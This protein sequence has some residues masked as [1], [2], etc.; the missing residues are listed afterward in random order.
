MARPLRVLFVA[1]EIAPL[2]SSGELG[3]AVGGLAGALK[4]LGVDVRVVIPKYKT[5]QTQTSGATRLVPKM[6]IQTI[7]RFGETAI[8]R[9]EL[10]GELPV[11]LLEKDKYFQREYLYGSPEQGYED[12]AERFS[13]F[14]LATLES[15]SQIGFYPDV[16]H[17]HDWHTGLIPVY[18][19]TLFKHDP[20]YTPFKTAYTIHDLLHQGRFTWNDF[21][22]TGL[23]EAI[24][25]QEGLEYYG[26]FS[27][28]KAGIVYADIVNTVSKRYSQEIQT[29]DYGYGFEGL[30]QLR[31]HDLYG[32]LNGV[33]YKQ[34]NPRM[35]AFIAANYTRDE[36][37]KKRLCKADLLSACQWEAETHKP[38]IGMIAPLDEQK[39]VDLL[40][41]VLPDIVAQDVQMI[42]LHNDSFYDHFYAEQLTKMAV[43]YPAQFRYYPDY[44]QALAHKILAGADLLLL[45]SQK[46][47]CGRLQMYSLKYGTIPLVRATGGLDDTILDFQAD[48]GKGNGFKFEAYTAE[49]LL[50]KLGEALEVYQNQPLWEL[51]RANAMRADYSWVYAAKKYLDL[52]KIAMHK[53][54][55]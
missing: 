13:F 39:G 24:Y 2:A 55:P 44:D 52:Y 29:P 53:G 49:A 4:S 14:N 50:A 43:E 36:V 7:N 28:L 31:S 21:S 35:D 11:Y 42:F 33:D 34:Y 46:E 12:N 54:R 30:L 23:P 20:L 48:S 41:H 37:E 9:D 27:F 8:Y 10:P 51:L 18:L 38:L 5:P 19:K 40:L 1:S 25:T 32:V 26:D 45:P 6:R 22:V 17:C 16:I 47:P 15:C 3:R